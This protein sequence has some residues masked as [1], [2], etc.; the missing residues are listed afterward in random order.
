ML[1]VEVA[2]WPR[3]VGDDISDGFKN[4]PSMVGGFGAGKCENVGVFFFGGLY[5]LPET[6][7]K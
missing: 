4:P 2:K 7:S 5:T 1:W 3:L 6:N